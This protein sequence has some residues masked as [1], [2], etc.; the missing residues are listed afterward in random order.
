V[1]A[2][3]RQPILG[4]SPSTGEQAL[5]TVCES[6]IV[7]KSHQTEH[8]SPGR[9]EGRVTLAQWYIA[10]VSTCSAGTEIHQEIQGFLS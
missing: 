9:V 8:R 10:V 4:T 6:A 5:E 1:E 2:F 3:L 7:S